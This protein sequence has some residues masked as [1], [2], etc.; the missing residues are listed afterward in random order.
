MQDVTSQPLSEDAART[1]SAGV[2]QVGRGNASG[3]ATRERLILLAERMFAE[4]GIEGTSL[5]AIGEAAGQRNKTAVQY[6]F[7]DRTALVSAIYAYRSEQLD[8]RRA[9]LLEAHRDAGEPDSPKVLLRIL[10]QPHVE[11]I[12]DPDNNFLPFLARL[13]LD[14]GSIANESS[15]GAAP[16]MSAHHELRQ[17]IRRANP[18]VPDE[19][20]D[21]RYDLLLTFSITALATHKRFSETTDLARVG[22]IA[23]EIVEIMAAGLAAPLPG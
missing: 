18:D 6:H 4:R 1:L 9:A 14:V 17:R 21:R 5:R 16:F 3:R 10:L 19:I 2:Q 12:A 22:D 8:A 11:S 15:G 20:F 23:D 7:G 13:V